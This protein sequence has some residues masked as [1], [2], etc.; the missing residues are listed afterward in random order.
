MQGAPVARES[1]SP[2]EKTTCAQRAIMT[3][4]QNATPGAPMF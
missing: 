4:L 1:R 2:E 3:S